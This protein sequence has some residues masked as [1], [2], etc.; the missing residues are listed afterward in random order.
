MQQSTF[1]SEAFPYL[2]RKG[3][4][5]KK[6]NETR[7]LARNI[8]RVNRNELR[9]EFRRLTECAPHRAARGLCYF[10]GAHNGVPDGPSDSNQYEPRLAMA[11]WKIEKWWPRPDGSQFR[12]LDYQVPLWTRRSGQGIGDVDLLGVTKQGQL[13]IIEM[14]AK[15]RGE[16]PA[17][18][19]LQRLRYAAIVQANQDVLA[20]HAK[21]RFEVRV[22]EEPPIIQIL[23]PRDW[24]HSWMQ[25]AKSTRRVA[26]DWERELGELAKDIEEQIGVT[27]EFVATDA[28]LRCIGGDGQPPELVGIPE[29]THL[30]L[31]AR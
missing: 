23:A 2:H 10:I 7:D 31:G 8:K 29:F 28:E 15:P 27:I 24:W 25:L 22:A 1:T 5:L 4:C 3:E 20:Q 14:K 9:D 12:L 19:M 13:M 16:T 6:L 17:K 18:A 11:L 26:G 21:R 30:S